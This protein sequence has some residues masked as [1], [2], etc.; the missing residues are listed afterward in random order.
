MNVN[1]GIGISPIKLA[2]TLT[3]YMVPLKNAVSGKNGR[4]RINLTRSL[5]EEKGVKVG[6]TNVEFLTRYWL[7]HYDS[8]IS[9][10]F[11][12]TDFRR[13]APDF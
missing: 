1:R 6:G 13:T 8:F 4:L 7:N 2:D 3:I 11:G 12:G 5:V 9:T 10:V